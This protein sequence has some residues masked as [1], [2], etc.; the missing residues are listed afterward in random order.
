MT[1]QQLREAL[2]ELGWS[3]RELAR[4][5]RVHQNTVTQWMRGEAP[6][7]AE[8]YVMLALS[9]KRLAEQV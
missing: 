2:S 3:Q 8:A 6:G 9:V 5:L 7:Y 4:R 1:G